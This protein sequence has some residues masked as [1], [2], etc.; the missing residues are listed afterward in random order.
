M[1]RKKQRGDGDAAGASATAPSAAS[2]AAQNEPAL[3]WGMELQA[4]Q[5]SS[6]ARLTDDKLA[7]FALGQQ[8]KTKFEK[9]PFGLL[10][11][12]ACNSSM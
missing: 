2:A 9:V 6:L 7:R 12:I 5:P 4:M 11:L 3:P 1:G 10:Q 8:R